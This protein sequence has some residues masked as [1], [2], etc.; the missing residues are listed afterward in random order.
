MNTI[1]GISRH[2]MQFT[3]MDNFIAGDNPARIIDAFVGK[4]DLATLR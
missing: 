3:S 2:Q 4:H 1:Q